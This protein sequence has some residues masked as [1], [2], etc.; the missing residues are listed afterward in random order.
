MS[1]LS[2]NEPVYP[3]SILIQESKDIMRE[4]NIELE[5]YREVKVTKNGWCV[6][7]H[8][9]YSAYRCHVTE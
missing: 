6:L 4:M 5:I 9:L 1:K 7:D 2:K 3:Y 8:D